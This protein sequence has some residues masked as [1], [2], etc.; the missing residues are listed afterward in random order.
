MSAGGLGC[1]A[2][3][4][5]K[6]TGAAGMVPGLPQAQGP[7]PDPDPTPSFLTPRN[8]KATLLLPVAGL[9][10]LLLASGGKQFLFSDA[11]EYH[12]SMCINRSLKFSF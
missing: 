11:H 9:S 3:G 10:L 6:G 12:A 7:D 8:H 1:R 5:N 4:W 2:E